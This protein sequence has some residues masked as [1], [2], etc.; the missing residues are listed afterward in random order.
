MTKKYTAQET[1]DMICEGLKAQS[2]CKSA[3]RVGS[4]KYRSSDNVK[5]AVGQ[6]IPDEEY[7]PEFDHGNGLASDIVFS[8]SKTLQRH[9]L[10]LLTR[11]QKTHDHAENSEDMKRRFASLAETFKLEW[12]HE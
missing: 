6:L 2:W 1:F 5:C 11:A 8:R 10:F 12:K 9:A 7:D 4:C 3:T